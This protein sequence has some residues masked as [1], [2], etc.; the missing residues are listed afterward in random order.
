MSISMNKEKMQAPA[1]E[2]AK[3]V[4]TPL[5]HSETPMLRVYYN[6]PPSK[7]TMRSSTSFLNR[8]A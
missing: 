7:V 5:L 1:N 4:K 8:S 2:L 6:E 3:E